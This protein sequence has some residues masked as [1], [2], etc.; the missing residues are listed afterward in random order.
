MI[1]RNTFTFKI[2]GSGGAL[3]KVPYSRT[4]EQYWYG[5]SVWIHLHCLLVQSI[6]GNIHRA[7]IAWTAS[8]WWY[9]SHVTKSSRHL[10]HPTGYFTLSRKRC[11]GDNPGR[12]TFA[13]GT[14]AGASQMGAP[15][16]LDFS[17]AGEFRHGHCAHVEVFRRSL[18]AC[19]SFCGVV[20][21]YALC[22]V[23]NPLQ[24]SQPHN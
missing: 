16:P 2:F 24:T 11:R 3:E 23:L 14:P 22:V 18:C 10:R 15:R 6:V 13:Q 1:S 12:D 8:L 17:I 21:Q 5:K 4:H 20:L 7:L 19:G 9:L